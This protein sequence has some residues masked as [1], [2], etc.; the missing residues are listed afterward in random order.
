M[1]LERLPSSVGI[2]PAQQVLSEAQLYDASLIISGDTVPTPHWP[3][4]QPVGTILPVR[5]VRGAVEI[6][7]HG[8]IC[9]KVTEVAADFFYALEPYLKCAISRCA[10]SRVVPEI[11]SRQTGQ[12]GKAAR[13][14]TSQLVTRE[15]QSCEVGEVAQLCWNRSS[16]L[17]TPEVQSCE[18]GEIAQFAGN[19]TGYP[20]GPA[21]RGC[22]DRPVVWESCR[23][24][25]CL[26]GPAPRGWRGCPVCWNRTSQLVTPEVQ[27]CPQFGR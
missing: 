18:V 21:P 8:P 24:T 10:Q 9:R 15:V 5:A 22:R 12:T 23:S 20:R 13:N 4:A 2:V 11:E 25:G 6:V 19:S 16:Q 26:R 1:R 3:I 7:Q 14:R 17:V 27:S